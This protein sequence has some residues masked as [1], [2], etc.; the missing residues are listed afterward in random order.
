MV[1]KN[2]IGESLLRNLCVG[3]GT[4]NESGSR[5]MYDL[6][7]DRADEVKYYLGVFKLAL[8]LQAVIF[9]VIPRAPWHFWAQL[10]CLYPVP[11]D[12]LYNSFS[13]SC[14]VSGWLSCSHTRSKGRSSSNRTFL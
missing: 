4:T 3:A 8:A 10:P 6:E 2:E 9:K 14:R 5:F 1:V 12:V 7:E 13:S 11:P